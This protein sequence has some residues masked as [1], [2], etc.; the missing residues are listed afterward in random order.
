MLDEIS[1]IDSRIIT[2]SFYLTPEDIVDF[3]FNDNI[4]L[5]FGDGGQYYK[6]NKID[7]YDPTTI[8]TCRI[9]LIKTKDITV[10]TAPKDVKP[11]WPKEK[12][13]FHPTIH[14]WRDNHVIGP[15]V[16]LKGIGNI[17]AKTDVFVKGNYNNI[18]EKSFISGD[19]NNIQSVKA[20]IIGDKNTTPLNSD[21]ALIIGDTN[22]I[23]EGTENVKIIGN[24]STSNVSNV[25]I[26]GDGLNVTT[27]NS[28]N[29]GGIFILENNY[30]TGGRDEILSPFSEN[31]IINYINGGRDEVRELGSYTNINI[32]SAG[33][34]I[35][36]YKI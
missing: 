20:T 15:R 22:N 21:R 18:N 13:F 32:I 17:V 36:L 2:A 33:R 16:I 14:D 34:D 28:T 35:V 24:D 9:E 7:G 11:K 30:V 26:I 19:N 4:F 3:K 6:V 27:P 5:D 1:D 10:H 8:K 31:S 12:P 23:V 29:V 25:F